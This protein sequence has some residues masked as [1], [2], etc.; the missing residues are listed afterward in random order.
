MRTVLDIVLFL[1]HRQQ[2]RLAVL[3]CGCTSG[4]I[5]AARLGRLRRQARRRHKRTPA[6]GG[7][8]DATL[9]R[10]T[11]QE[12]RDTRQETVDKTQETEDKRRDAGDRRQ[13]SC[14]RVRPRPQVAREEEG[15]GE[16]RASH[17]PISV[18]TVDSFSGLYWRYSLHKAM[19]RGDSGRHDG[20][21]SMFAA[22]TAHCP[23]GD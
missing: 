4:W 22:W 8:I 13:E 14:P 12:T 17:A 3:R 6:H 23:G 7:R 2:P 5:S 19:T 11:G 9:T 10:D 21:Q 16:A 15:R 20:G 18:S 1:D